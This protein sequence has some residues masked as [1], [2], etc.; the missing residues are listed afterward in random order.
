ML[1]ANIPERCYGFISKPDD[2][3]LFE[4]DS[5]DDRYHGELQCNCGAQWLGVTR[6]QHF[7]LHSKHALYRQWLP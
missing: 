5:N 1:A 7:Q 3:A 6:K 4:F 2:L